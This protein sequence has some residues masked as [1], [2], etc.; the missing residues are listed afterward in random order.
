M[1]YVRSAG[2]LG[3]Q[4]FQLTA[5]LY[6]KEKVN[7]PISFYTNH[8]KNYETPREFL[9]QEILPQEFP[10]QFVK[11]RLL[12]Q[13]ILK[14]RVNKVLPFLFKW[15]I[16]TKNIASYKK[17]NFYVLDDYF[18][19]IS[20][21]EKE[22]QIVSK[23]IQQKANSNKK[24]IE[25]CNLHHQFKDSVAIHIRQGDFLNKANATTFYTQSNGYYKSAIASLKNVQNLFI[26]SE[27]EATF[28][29]DISNYP[30][31]FVKNFS[32]TDIEEFL[33][34]SK[35]SNLIIAN[36]TYSFWAA[37]STNKNQIIAP[38]NWFYNHKQNNVWLKNLQIINFK[39]I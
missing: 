26:F 3:N 21:F 20:V 5:A 4:L 12:V 14:Y 16:T 19:D 27:T 9:L 32:L 31:Q 38:K 8:L 17:S 13:L 25:I 36:S 6:L 22:L 24:V 37:V 39:T 30:T 1:I 10:L 35:F 29:I 7:M 18:Q 28:I 34:M 23:Y 2:G 15:S 11:P 33:L